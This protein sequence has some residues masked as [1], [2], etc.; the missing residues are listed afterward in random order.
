MWRM[1]LG[2]RIAVLRAERGWSAQQLADLANEAA[3]RAGLEFDEEKPPATQQAIDRLE[4]RDSQT[5][6]AAPFIAEA[7]GVSLRWLLTGLGRPTDSNGW[8]FPLVPRGS[9]DAAD[10]EARGYVQGV[11]KAALKEIETAHGKPQRAAA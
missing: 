11:L 6:T 7:F 8:P 1:N 3:R 5:S 4:K 9:W 10:D 2:Q